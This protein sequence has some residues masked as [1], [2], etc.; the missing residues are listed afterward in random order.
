MLKNDKLFV[1]D[2]EHAR[3]DFPPIFDFYSLFLSLPGFGYQ[4]F[5]SKKIKYAK[6]MKDFLK[7]DSNSAFWFFWLFLID[8]LYLQF[9]IGAKESGEK[10]LNFLEGVI[11]NEKYY[12]DNWSL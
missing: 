11:E 7:L 2:W 1:V 5:F 12:K 6:E 8:Q 4:E 3:F 9:S 10:I